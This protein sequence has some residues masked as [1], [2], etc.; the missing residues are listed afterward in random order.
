MHIL[1]GTVNMNGFRERHD[2]I[3]RRRGASLPDS[4]L[5]LWSLYF[6]QQWSLWREAKEP[7]ARDPGKQ[8]VGFCTWT[9]TAFLCVCCFSHRL[10]VL[11]HTF[12]SQRIYKSCSH[13]LSLHSFTSVFVHTSGNYLIRANI[14]L[15]QY[16]D[17]VQRRQMQL[18]ACNWLACESTST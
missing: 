17:T 12:K 14:S 9:L 3:A 6:L 10:S 8:L 11:G 1:S 13:V 4:T 18:Q 15:S 5:S 7:L 16:T 2:F